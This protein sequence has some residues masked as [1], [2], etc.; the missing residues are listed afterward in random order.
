M[1][2]DSS[3]PILLLVVGIFAFFGWLL[4]LTLVLAQKKNPYIKVL[5][6]SERKNT[7]IVMLYKASRRVSMHLPKRNVLPNTDK[8][9][10]TL[11][12]PEHH[13]LK[14]VPPSDKEYSLEKTKLYNYFT[15]LSMPLTATEAA[16]MT[17]FNNILGKYGIKGND[18]A[19]DALIRCNLDPDKMLPGQLSELPY[20]IDNPN[21][22]IRDKGGKWLDEILQIE[23]EDKREEA[24]ERYRLKA[25]TDDD[26]L[27]L[28]EIDEEYNAATAEIEELEKHKLALKKQYQKITGQIDP[29]TGEEIVTLR[30]IQAELKRTVV[31][32]GFFVWN[33]AEKFATIYS[34]LQAKELDEIKA[35]FSANSMLQNWIPNDKKDLK[36]WAFIVII[37]IIAVAALKTI[38]APA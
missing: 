20:P 13:G 2:M 7:P 27:E 36:Q 31:E 19:I 28:Q 24:L 33:I 5:L 16:A 32:D 8:K 17:Q 35:T 22:K 1:I 3:S 9:D 12:L 26:A 30:S 10:N 29:L 6:Q 38:M 14:F 25:I 37:A 11:S 21:K 4:L 18:N 34:G 23:D 15:K